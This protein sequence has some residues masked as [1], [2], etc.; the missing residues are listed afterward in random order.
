MACHVTDDMTHD[1]CCIDSHTTLDKCQILDM[2]CLAWHH[3]RHLSRHMPCDVVGALKAKGHWSVIYPL[4][5]PRKGCSVID[6]H[7]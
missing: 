1:M 2:C 4:V 5:Q 6:S 7:K 3:T